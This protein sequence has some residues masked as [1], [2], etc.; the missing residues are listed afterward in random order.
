MYYIYTLLQRFA[1]Q[2]SRELR[3]WWGNL[4]LDTGLKGYSAVARVW[5]IFLANTQVKQGSLKPS[6][7]IEKQTQEGQ[8]SP[9]RS[10]D[11][12]SSN[13]G[14]LVL[15]L[16]GQCPW[17]L[18]TLYAGWEGS[19]WVGDPVQRLNSEP[20]VPSVS[21]VWII[22]GAMDSWWMHLKKTPRSRCRRWSSK[23]P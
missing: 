17:N 20:R 18:R 2:P 5:C 12:Q 16:P 19:R 22:S 6:R 23:C 15:P 3:A 9:S 4:I 7:K 21:S 11:F 8:V 10:L 14:V 1:R 13:D